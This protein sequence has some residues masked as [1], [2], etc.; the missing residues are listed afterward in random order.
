MFH[1]PRGSR[2]LQDTSA[3]P[4]RCS[5]LQP[6]LGPDNLTTCAPMRH[7]TKALDVSTCIRTVTFS[8]TAQGAMLLSLHYA[9]GLTD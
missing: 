4:L 8:T 3:L 1:F 9:A 2:E 5:C 7:V 6:R